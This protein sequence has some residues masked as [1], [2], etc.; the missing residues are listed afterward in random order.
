MNDGPPDSQ[1]DSSPRGQEFARFRALCRTVFGVELED[2]PS[3]AARPSYHDVLLRD[4]WDD[5]VTVKLDSKG[6]TGT[7]PPIPAYRLTIWFGQGILGEVPVERCV[8]PQSDPEAASRLK[9]WYDEKTATVIRPAIDHWH[10]EGVVEEELAGA[11][12]RADA[13]VGFDSDICVQAHLSDTSVVSVTIY[14]PAEMEKASRDDSYIAQDP[15]RIG[16]FDLTRDGGMQEALTAVYR[17]S[18]EEAARQKRQ[19]E[20]REPLQAFID[21]LDRDHLDRTDSDPKTWLTASVFFR[22]PANVQVE[23]RDGS[24]LIE[25]HSFIAATDEDLRLI[26]EWIAGVHEKLNPIKDSA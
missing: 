4:G 25:Y 18:R 3:G 10:R 1:T 8:V 2:R 19:A 15:L 13:E 12:R 23:L 24:R 21:Q 17:A 6:D 26:R 5:L 11:V 22:P 9:T 7:T 20:I 14:N 16:D